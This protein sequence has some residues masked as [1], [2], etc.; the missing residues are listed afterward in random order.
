MSQ[1][2]YISLRTVRVSV[3]VCDSD[4]Y[5]FGRLRYIS[6]SKFKT[7]ID[8]STQ[9]QRPCLRCVPEPRDAYS[10]AIDPMSRRP[11]SAFDLVCACRTTK[12]YTD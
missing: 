1:I 8:P 5:G 3:L 6:T 11:A 12:R 10:C 4:S 7:S 9:K 2:T